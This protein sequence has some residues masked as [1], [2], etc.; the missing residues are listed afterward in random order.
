MARQQSTK[1]LREPTFESN[2]KGEGEQVGVIENP[3]EAQKEH[4]KESLETKNA[5]AEK[6]KFASEGEIACEH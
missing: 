3:E 4:K 1:G 5:N 2:Q 6:G